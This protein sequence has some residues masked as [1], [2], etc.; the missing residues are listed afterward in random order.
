M[1]KALKLIYICL[2]V[3]IFLTG[4]SPVKADEISI[5]TTETKVQLSK[6]EEIFVKKNLKQYGYNIFNSKPMLSNSSTSA[7]YKINEGDKLNI[8]L[9][10]DS[11]DLLNISANGFLNPYNTASVDNQGNIFVQGVGIIPAKGKTAA[12]TEKII[13]GILSQKIENFKI[14]VNVANSENFPI[15]VTGNVKN[16]GTFYINN[17][18]S[19]IEILSLAGGIEKDG[20]LRNIILLSGSQ[21][22]EIDLYDLLI[23]GKN[24]NFTVKKGDVILV[25]PLGNVVGIAEGVRRPAIYEFKPKES[26]KDIISYAGGILPSVSKDTIIIDTFDGQKFIKNIIENS[27][28]KTTAILPHNGDVIEFKTLFDSKATIEVSGCIANQGLFPYKENMTLKNLLDKINFDKK[29]EIQP[30]KNSSQKETDINDIIAEVSTKTDDGKLIVKTVYLYELLTKNRED[31]TLKP[32]D[33]ILFRKLSDK[34]NLKTVEVLG[35]VNK[36]GVFKLTSDMTLSDAIELAG[37]ISEQGY[38]KGLVLLRPS[39]SEEQKK[40]MEN[41]TLDLKQN[42]LERENQSQIVPE[43]DKNFLSTQ[44]ELVEIMDKKANSEYGRISLNINAASM[45]ELLPEDDIEL[46]DG[47]KIYIPIKPQHIMIVGEVLNPTAIAYYDSKTINDYIRGVGGLTKTADKKKIYIRKTNGFAQ[48]VDKPEKT[49][50]EPGDS[51]II[52]RKIAKSVD[53]FDF[54]KSFSSIVSNTLNMVFVLTKI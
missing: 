37:D 23:K 7:N 12:E 1:K 30:I 20:S 34:E 24:P 9:W 25:K 36:P 52:P 38:L 48:R 27:F 39:I 2:W 19:I 18:F 50:L 42:I 53:W 5:Q 17:D 40:I 32:N 21:K 6:T 43:Q 51:I 45:D 44:K 35:Y 8:Y 29:A 4:I 10:G 49:Y 28:E 46:Q 14:T 11:I 33:K 13:S 54:S 26:L 3:V 22:H 47:D 31:V 16:P 41:V 15:I